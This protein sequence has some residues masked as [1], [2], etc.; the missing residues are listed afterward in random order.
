M[1]KVNSE[2]II[3]YIAYRN[4]SNDT[5]A[6]VLAARLQDWRKVLALRINNKRHAKK[7][8]LISHNKPEVSPANYD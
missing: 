8:K 5:T 2:S 3:K 6:K 7:P 1:D 4:S